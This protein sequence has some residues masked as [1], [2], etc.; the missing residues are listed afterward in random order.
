MF[1]KTELW[2][3][4]NTGCSENP[5]HR[6]F[7]RAGELNGE[8]VTLAYGPTVEVREMHSHTVSVHSR[9]RIA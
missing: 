5:G 7:I 8:V 1:P 6:D 9:S 4:A 3:N 2:G